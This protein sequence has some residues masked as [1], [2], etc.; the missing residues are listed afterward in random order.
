M[1]T[2]VE[3]HGKGAFFAQN[4]K[5]NFEIWITLFLRVFY[6]FFW[7]ALRENGDETRSDGGCPPPNLIFGAFQ[8][9]SNRVDELVWAGLFSQ[10]LKAETTVSFEAECRQ[11]FLI[12]LAAAETNLLSF[13]I[14]QKSSC[15]SPPNG[16]FTGIQSDKGQT[17]QLVFGELSKGQSCT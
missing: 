12:A 9:D 6:L 2:L 10:P 17:F 3:S 7:S 4:R 5:K 1:C 16:S 15:L 14:G 8:S 11:L 13:S